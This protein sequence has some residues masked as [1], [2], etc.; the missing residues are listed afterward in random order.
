[1]HDEIISVDVLGEFLIDTQLRSSGIAEVDLP[2]VLLRFGGQN[3]RGASSELIRTRAS[4]L[5]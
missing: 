4:G 1:M 5:E 2:G 3:D